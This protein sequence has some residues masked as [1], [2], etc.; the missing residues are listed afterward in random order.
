MI[1][2]WGLF[3]TNF[4]LFV[5]VETR[6]GTILLLFGPQ[7]LPY[8]YID[9]DVYS[10]DKSSTTSDLIKWLQVTEAVA[11]GHSGTDFVKLTL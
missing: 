1:K 11:S 8:F 7:K 4:G 9:T 10:W 6:I 3:S 5:C 2:A